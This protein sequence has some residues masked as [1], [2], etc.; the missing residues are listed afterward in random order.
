VD[1][2]SIMNDVATRHA[3]SP[4][5][6]IAYQVVGDGSVTILVFKPALF[7]VDLMW[8]EPALARFV[9]GLASFSRSIWFDPRGTGSSDATNETEGTHAETAAA[10][11]LA[12]LDDIGCERAVIFGINTAAALLFAA[13]HPER[14]EALVLYN[15]SAR[16]RLADDYPEGIPHDIIDRVSAGLASE[17]AYPIQRL[18]PAPSMIGN[19]RFERWCQ[20]AVRLSG[21]PT[22]RLWRLR[23]TL[24]VDLRSVLPTIRVPTLVCQRGGTERA[25][26]QGRYVAEHIRGARRIELPGSDDLFFA[27]DPSLLLD[28]IE[29]FVTGNR[30][31]RRADRVL[32]TVMFT[33][34][35][36]STVHARRKGDRR[37]RELLSTHD[38]VLRAELQHFDGREIKTIGDGMLATFAS[39]DRALRCS[40][41]MRDAVRSLGIE[42]RVGLHTGEI[43][44]RG[45]DIGGIAVHIAGRIQSLACGSEILVS[46]TVA[47]LVAGSGL[48]FTERDAHELRGI[49]GSRRLYALTT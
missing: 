9:T 35:V 16:R 3:N 31:V 14:T 39:P 47:D 28:A 36:G 5:G 8:E 11:M 19:D 48:R 13:T 7:P 41:A 27:G 40:A 38:A 43:E 21:T 30:P 29:E 20:R 46:R 26:A 4:A 44:L 10:D 33:D 1:R 25:R 34:I 17:D 2:A 15:A 22:H 18:I 49:P 37:W 24:E 6:G 45:S 12:V 32:A 42:I 23:S